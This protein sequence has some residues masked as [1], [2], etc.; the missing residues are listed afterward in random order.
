MIIT[1]TLKTMFTK[2]LI[3]IMSAMMS[4]MPY[5]MGTLLGNISTSTYGNTIT[6]FTIVFTVI[7]IG[8]MATYTY[9]VCNDDI[10]SDWFV[11]GLL[12]NTFKI[13]PVIFITKLIVPIVSGMGIFGYVY[14]G[15]GAL[16]IGAIAITFEAVAK[17]SIGATDNFTDA[18]DKAV[19]V[20]KG[21]YLKVAAVAFAFA[22]LQTVLVPNYSGATSIDESDVKIYIEELDGYWYAD[23]LSD[24]LIKQIGVDIENEIAE[25]KSETMQ[26][27]L[28][29]GLLQTISNAFILI[30]CAHH[31]VENKQITDAAMKRL[32][33]DY[34]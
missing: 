6:V 22:I 10:S 34:T 15:A 5:I 16:F 3:L 9:Q 2:P 12:R 19:S 26:Q 18:L 30:F 24:E 11:H 27:N 17:V 7:F 21:I 23:E 29:Y 28:W 13:I 14:F 20:T 1:K 32:N 33:V 8:P 4:L 31:F 25:L